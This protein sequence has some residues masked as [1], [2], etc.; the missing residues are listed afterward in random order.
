MELSPVKVQIVYLS[1]ED[2][3][4]S[5]IDMLGW[6]KA[7][8]A[9]LVWPDHGRVLTRRIDLVLLKR[10]SLQHNI[11]IGFLTYDREIRDEA[12]E[13][14]IPVFDSL[15]DL[16][17]ED[18]VLG[19][20]S[21]DLFQR[22]EGFG[23]EQSSVEFIP[24]GRI[25]WFERL[26]TSQKVSIFLGILLFF[27]VI[28]S[29]FMPS[30][31]IILSPSPVK[32]TFD[33]DIDL[34]DA[35]LG[36]MSADLIPIQIITLRSKGESTKESSGLTQVPISAA[37]G[38]IIFT[39]LS[40]E[41]IVIPAGT[42]LRTT[43]GNGTRFKTTQPAILTGE[44]GSQVEVSIEALNPGWSGNVPANSITLVDGSLGLLVAVSNQ[45]PTSGGQADT[46]RMVLQADL[47]ELEEE[48]INELMASA[49]R[50]WVDSKTSDRI[51]VEDSLE[52]QGVLSRRFDYDAGDVADSIS[53]ELIVE[54]SALA[55]S[56]KDLR[57][58]AM[59][60][61]SEDLST[62][63]LPIPGTFTFSSQM[64][65]AIDRSDHKWIEIT[66]GLET[67]DVF[68]VVSMKRMIR[69]L[70]LS[71]AANLLLERYPL[72][73]QPE[74]VLK[75]SWYPFLPILDQRIDFSWS[76]EKGL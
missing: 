74:F 14:G 33:F 36:E 43:E 2:D 70:N 56:S 25:G 17:E 47:V 51:P 35:D 15:D 23:L 9:L 37:T 11:E 75:P 76:W 38:H 20:R 34:V 3:I 48:L 65:K 13:L 26:K 10:F 21:Q 22:R 40:Q 52:L 73:Q 8:R 49:E 32:R 42:T 54:F 45:E 53:L 72:S 6:V 63:E 1:P 5:T 69:G 62:N 58:L 50:E 55:L 16:P 68:D 31:Q 19:D 64:E 7:S 12:A 60:N 28:I 18:W 66:V 67:Y 61:L 24:E 27:V 30:A 57:A 46:R 41:T 39:S 4:H 71:D 44:V 29:L 59:T